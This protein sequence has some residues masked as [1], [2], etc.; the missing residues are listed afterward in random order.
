MADDWN[1]RS[2]LKS[3][4]IS[5]TSLWKGNL[6]MR[7]SV[8]FWYR[9]ISRRAT[10]PGLYLWGFLTPPDCAGADFRAALLASETCFL[11]AF[12]PMDFLAVCLVRA[13]CNEL[14]KLCEEDGERLDVGGEWGAY[15]Q[16]GRHLHHGRWNGSR[17]ESSSDQFARA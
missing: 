17:V 10:V 3:C 5:L 2:V 16:V 4:A 1:R 9:R 12:P 6:R 15:K 8:D 11:G 13:I 7:S 14:M